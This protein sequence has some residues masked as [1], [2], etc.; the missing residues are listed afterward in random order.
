MRESLAV[1]VSF[2]ER[3]LRIRAEPQ[4]YYLTPHYVE[5]PMVLARLQRIADGALR[6]LLAAGLEYVGRSVKGKAR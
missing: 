5:H 1:R 6:D 4:T 3:D 2:M